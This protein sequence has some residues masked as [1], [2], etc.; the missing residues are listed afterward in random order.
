MALDLLVKPNFEQEHIPAFDIEL[1]GLLC[2]DIA[3]SFVRV[4]KAKSEVNN[5]D[6]RSL[7]SHI[8]RYDRLGLCRWATTLGY[9]FPLHL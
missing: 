6:P 4:L 1:Q 9:P 3:S 8:S 7:S 2:K 5:C